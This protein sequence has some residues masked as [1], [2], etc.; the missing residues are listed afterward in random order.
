[1]TALKYA[2]LKA[3]LSLLPRTAVEE[4][5]GVLDYGARKYEKNN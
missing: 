1:M 5:A 4:I 2:Y 3:P